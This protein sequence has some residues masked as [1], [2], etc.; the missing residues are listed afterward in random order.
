MGLKIIEEK[1]WT[2]R[3]TDNGNPVIESRGL[4]VT[5]RGLGEVP[6][7][8]IRHYRQVGD[9]SDRMF[10]PITDKKDAYNLLMTIA[11]ALEMLDLD[12]F[13]G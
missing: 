13:D 5:V 6:G 1:P 4:R 2:K 12:K 8:H 11:K 7:I 3:L 10:I 9:E